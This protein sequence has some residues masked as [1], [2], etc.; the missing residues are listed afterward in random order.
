MQMWRGRLDRGNGEHNWRTSKG[1]FLLKVVLFCF[2]DRVVLCS[3]EALE[4]TM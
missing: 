1:P 2:L 4:L 3:K